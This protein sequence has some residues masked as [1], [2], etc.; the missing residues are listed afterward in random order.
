MAKFDDLYPDQH[1]DITQMAIEFEG[2][3]LIKYGEAG[4]CWHCG[5]ET[6]WIDISFEAHLCSEECE[7][8]KWKE[9]AETFN[10]EQFL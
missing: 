3:E 10:G 5:D 4:I 2:S 7:R 6:E 8:A 1:T 9:Y